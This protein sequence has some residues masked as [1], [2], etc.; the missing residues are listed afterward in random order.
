MG[1]NFYDSKKYFELLD[2]YLRA[3]NYLSVAQLYLL[4]NPLLREPLSMSQI[5]KKIVGHW[6]TVPG[7]NFIYAHI[8]R[9]ICKY[10]LNMIYISGPGH[11]GN[12]FIANSYL[13][14]RYSEVYPQIGEDEKGMTKLCKQFSFPCGVSSHVAPETPGSMHEGGELGYSLLHGMGAVLDNKDLIA[15][16]VVGDGEAETGPLATSWHLNKFLNPKTDGAVLPILHLNGYKISGPTV[17][18][19]MPKKEL[20]FLLKGYG[21]DPIFV[22]GDDTKKMHP[23]MAK[24]MDEC[25]TSIKKIQ[26]EARSGKTYT[27]KA[28]PMIVLRTPKGWTAPKIVDGKPME[29]SFRAHQVPLTL[30]GE[31][32]FEILKKWLESYHAEELFDENYRLKQEIKDI[33]PKGDK[34]ISANPVTNGGLLLKDLK[35]PNIYDYAVETQGHGKIKS[36]DMLELGK[37]MRDIFVLNKD[38]HNYRIFSPD[39]ANS[40]RIGHVFDVE[41]RNF[42]ETIYPYDENL[43]QDGRVMDSYLSEHACEGWL[44]GYILTGRHGVFVTYEAFARVV[45]SMI[46]QH[47]KWLKITRA[48]PWRK[49]ISSLNLVLTSNIWQQDHNG[50]THQEPGLLDHLSNKKSEIVRIYLP[51]DTNCLLSCYDHCQASKNYINVIVASKHPSYQWLSMDEAVEHCTKGLS[52]WQWASSC[53]EEETPDLVLA[54]AGDT[55]TLEALACQTLL[56]KYTPEVKVRFVNIVD[57]MKLQSNSAHPHGL[58]EMEFDDIFTKNKPIIFNFHG[59]QKFVHGLSMSRRN[60]NIEI[61]GYE[62]EGTIT[63]AFDI[64]VQNK[65]DRYHLVK[66]VINKLS[67]NEKYKDVLDEMDRLLDKHIKYIAKYGVDMPE[68]TDWKWE[69]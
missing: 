43:S 12:F 9:V 54:C 42:Q 64:R 8:D 6:G 16:V 20:E 24:A 45:D 39:E 28:W 5:K 13:E 56:K 29:G 1:K 63:T 53:K 61:H 25:I 62:E 4:K 35:L 52:V 46:S 59:Y 18:A 10:D 34:R 23:Q 26:K 65:I 66:A 27:R 21:W 31:G 51:P 14:G 11:G 30:E 47:A 40:N 55:P 3:T 15:T 38:N 17:M 57:I 48:L 68:V 37:Y 33:L 69:E 22:E 67:L 41:N 50:Y 60:K 36:Q 2:K 49:P 19:R 58:T 7:Q 32:H 44:E